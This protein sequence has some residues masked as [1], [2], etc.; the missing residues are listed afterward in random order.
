MS[1]P[2]PTLQQLSNGTKLFQNRAPQ[3]FKESE[4]RPLT[5][6]L[7]YVLTSCITYISS[8]TRHPSILFRHP[9][10]TLQ[11]LSNGTKRFQYRAP[12]GFKESED[13]PLTLTLTLTLT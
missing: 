5:L 10:P 7:C 12:Q 6:T 2:E 9:E 8:T 11:Q 4:D 1:N 3:G 13:R